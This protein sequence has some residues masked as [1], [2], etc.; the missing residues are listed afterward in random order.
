MDGHSTHVGWAMLRPNSLN[1]V[2]A[3][4]YFQVQQNVD[5]RKNCGAVRTQN[6]DFEKGCLLSFTKQKKKVINRN[7]GTKIPKIYMF[8][9]S[10]ICF[11]RR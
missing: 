11:L 8:G 3:R 1:P 5:R 9:Y 7:R 2:K 4:R 10:K 6:I